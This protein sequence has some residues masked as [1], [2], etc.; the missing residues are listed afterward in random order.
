M[1]EESRGKRLQIAWVTL[2]VAMSLY[3]IINL[4]VGKCYYCVLVW[5][6]L[7]HV[8]GKSNSALIALFKYW[9]VLQMAE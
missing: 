4:G 2:Y 1:F 7:E 5:T 6:Q 8:D 9:I 3:T